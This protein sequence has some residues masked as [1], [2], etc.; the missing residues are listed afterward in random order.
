MT[1]KTHNQTCP[2][3]EIPWC[4]DT[5]D[6]TQTT[7]HRLAVN[8]MSG[9]NGGACAS[10]VGSFA[11]DWRDVTCLECLTFQPRCRMCQKL[12]AE[13]PKLYAFG[14]AEGYCDPCSSVAASEGKP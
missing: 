13:Q 7:V 2:R 12:I 3:C 5:C 8:L 9:R 4:C 1:T 6:C 11:V 10:V 14:G